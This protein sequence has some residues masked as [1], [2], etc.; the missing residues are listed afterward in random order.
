MK[1]NAVIYWRA[2]L[3]R[4]IIKRSEA[5]SVKAGKAPLFTMTFIAGRTTKLRNSGI[6]LF[7]PKRVFTVADKIE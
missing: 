7:L 5:S 4:H 1:P 2:G 3:P 6:C